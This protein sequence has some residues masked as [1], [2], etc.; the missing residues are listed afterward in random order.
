MSL[1]SD[2]L[3]DGVEEREACGGAVTIHSST[4]F[5]QGDRI[6]LRAGLADRRGSDGES[7]RNKREVPR[8]ERLARDDVMTI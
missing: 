1:P 5:S 4:V 8:T 7:S 2:R 6:L 3:V